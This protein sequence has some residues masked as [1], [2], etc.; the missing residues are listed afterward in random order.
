[1]YMP[2]MPL[3]GE[4]NLRSQVETEVRTLAHNITWDCVRIL[5][6]LNPHTLKPSPLN[7]LGSCYSCALWL[8]GH[9]HRTKLFQL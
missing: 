6:K 7:I 3:E 8:S 2:H 4:V 5:A 1:M 9:Y